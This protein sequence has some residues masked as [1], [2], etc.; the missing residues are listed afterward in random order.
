MALSP[1]IDL[2]LTARPQ[3]SLAYEIYLSLDWIFI[4]I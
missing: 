2:K 1:Q 4:I 3:S